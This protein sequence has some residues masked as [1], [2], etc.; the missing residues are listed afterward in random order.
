MRDTV[1][2]TV[3][4]PTGLDPFWQYVIAVLPFAVVVNFP[5]EWRPNDI[6]YYHLALQLIEPDALHPDSAIFDASNA[7]IV[8]F[9]IIAGF[10]RLFGMHYAMLVVSLGL[11]LVVSSGLA[12]IARV[13]E[14]RAWELFAVVA[15]FFAM[16]QQLFSHER[17]LHG[18][19]TKNLAYA[20]ILPAIAS[21]FQDRWKMA[22]GLASVA[23]YCHFLVGGLWGGF[24]LILALIRSDLKLA[25]KLAGLFAVV[26]L[27][28]ASFIL[29]ERSLSEG[30]FLSDLGLTLS[31]VYALYR[32]PHHVAPFEPAQLQYWLQ[33]I[34]VLLAAIPLCVLILRRRLVRRDLALWTT[35]LCVYLV[36]ALFV[37][38]FDRP[39]YRLGNFYLF[40]PNSLILFFVLSLFILAIRR[41]PIPGFRAVAIVV[42]A[43]FTLYT[44]AEFSVRAAERLM[45]DRPW[46]GVEGLGDEDFN[47]VVRWFDENSSPDDVVIIQAADPL[48]WREDWVAFEW[49]TNRPTLVHFKF[50]PVDKKDMARW[51]RIIDWSNK[52]FEGECDR[53]GEYK[54]SFFVAANAASAS[55]LSACLEPAVTYGDVTIF[56]AGPVKGN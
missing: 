27:P 44:T 55:K 48:A 51:Y 11:A 52:V 5:V 7:R 9:S 10:I 53:I 21:A 56:P 19:E 8:G 42:A 13:L 45:Q 43:A 12:M 4:S 6:N 35:F 17:L 24:L 22:I 40:R 50:V 36:L 30:P 1:D 14:M 31:Q 47:K 32:V 29:Y 37:A 39:D 54:A 2:T 23:T 38:F 49:I 20:L 3:K 28:I 18:A 33:G 41:I 16:D 46:P 26:V 15:L 25:T 34:A